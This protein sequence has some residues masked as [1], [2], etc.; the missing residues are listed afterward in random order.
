MRALPPSSLGAAADI[1]RWIW[2]E[3][4]LD[5]RLRRIKTFLENEGY[6]LPPRPKGVDDSKAG[7]FHVLHGVLVTVVYSVIDQ[8]GREV[9]F[10]REIEIDHIMRR[11]IEKGDEWALEHL[12]RIPR[13]LKAGRVVLKGSDRVVYHSK[14]TYKRP[15][16][17]R[18]I[19]RVII[20]RSEGGD[21]YIATFHP[22]YPRG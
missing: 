16:G 17:E 3:K 15:T 6:L 11:R 12:F 7:E 22:K 18:C 19:L 5:G 4:T 21:W 9:Y 1:V 2:E 8:G 20:K 13:I 10:Y 14:E